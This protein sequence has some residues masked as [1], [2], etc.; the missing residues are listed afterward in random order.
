MAWWDSLIDQGYTLPGTEPKT[1]VNG[2][3]PQYYDTSATAQLMRG[4]SG[5]M[6][7]KQAEL[8]RQQKEMQRKA[9]MYKTLRDAGYEPE[10]AYKSVISNKLI[11][12]GGESSL[13]EQKK[14][15]EIE[16]TKAQTEYFRKRANKPDTEVKVSFDEA[17]IKTRDGEMDWEELEDKFPRKRKEIKELQKQFTPAKE[18]P[19]FRKGYGI[20]AFYS[21]NVA[22]M[23]PKAQ[24]MI[25][26]IKTQ[27]DLEQ[28]ME[29]VDD[30]IA[31][32]IFSD[33]DKRTVLEY[34]GIQ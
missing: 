25:N 33:N 3:E 12:P 28:F 6:K 8:E 31:S 17:L 22:K 7:L 2:G 1:I 9:D 16:K 30:K 13:E 20:E 4:L 23:T 32:K 26:Q 27:A 34:F 21:N 29:E 11:E 18:S 15:V 14:K 24:N 10:R 5:Y 19:K